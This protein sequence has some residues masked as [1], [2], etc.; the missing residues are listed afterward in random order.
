MEAQCMKMRRTE[1]FGKGRFRTS[2]GEDKALK[3]AFK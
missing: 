1:M 2:K 3:G